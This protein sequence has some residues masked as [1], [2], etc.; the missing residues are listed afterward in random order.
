MSTREGEHPRA[1][2]KLQALVR[3]PTVSH[4]DPADNDTAA[5]DR[6]LDELAR[7]FPL[8]H[9]RLELTRI[10][11]HALLF[12]SPGHS[13]ARPVVLRAH[14]DVVPVDEGLGSCFFGIPPERDRAVREEFGIPDSYDPVGVITIG[15][16]VEDTGNA[17]SPARRR[18]RPLEEVLH[19]GSWNG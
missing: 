5:F 4:R 15:H 19:R 8:L 11:S 13:A 12:H 16:R 3:I 14:L 6:F 2:G 18:R 9:E 1:V 17:G 7:Q 10:G